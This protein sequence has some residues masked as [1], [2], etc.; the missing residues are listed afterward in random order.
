MLGFSIARHR[1]SVI[2]AAAVAVVGSIALQPLARFDFNPLNMKDPTTESVA[3]FI[4]LLNDPNSTPYTIA[5]LG[6]DLPAA[7]ELAKKLKAL[8]TVE[9]TV[10]LASFLPED[11]DLKLGIIEDLNLS[12]G[13]VLQV[14]GSKASAPSIDDQTRAVESFLKTLRAAAAPTGRS[15]A[16]DASIKRL[17]RALAQLK[18]LPDWPERVIPILNDNV[19]ADLPQSIDKLRQLLTASA[20]ALD[21]LPAELR[22][23][24]LGKD[25]RAML[26]VFP[27]E[28]LRDK[29]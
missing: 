7:Q 15:A 19:V 22:A 26:Q 25:G 10:T 29:T 17:E 12:L 20:I 4:D 8:P 13:A 9:K 1:G 16:F 5:V 28:D 21:D 27:K 6:Q 24:Y 2:A 18:S 3:T 14:D 11:Q 23:R